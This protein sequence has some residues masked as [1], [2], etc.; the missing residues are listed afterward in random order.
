MM[1]ILTKTNSGIYNKFVR[2]CHFENWTLPKNLQISRW[3]SESLSDRLNQQ[4]KDTM[5]SKV[6]ND[7]PSS[8]PLLPLHKHRHLILDQKWE[9][10]L[11][12]TYTWFKLIIITQKQS[13]N[14][15]FTSN[16]TVRCYNYQN[17]ASIP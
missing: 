12:K 14:R 17:I 8:H 6:H 16:L 5:H 11:F 10:S 4:S 1:R 3:I 2:T 13:H 9:M 7:H 15:C